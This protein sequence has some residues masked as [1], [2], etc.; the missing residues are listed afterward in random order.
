MGEV[1]VGARSSCR[2]DVSPAC[3]CEQ[4][5]LLGGW[6]NLELTRRAGADSRQC[7]V[8]GGRWQ[9]GR[10]GGEGELESRMDARKGDVK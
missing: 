7:R 10:N 8:A 6:L 9:S 5:M 2:Q 4:V 1:A 3:L